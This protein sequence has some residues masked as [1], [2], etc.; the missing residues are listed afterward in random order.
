MRVGIV[1]WNTA[2]LLDACLASLATE[3]ARPQIEVVVVD[4]ASSDGSADV[5]ERHPGVRVIRNDS[6]VGYARAMNQALA[7]GDADVLVALNPDT[8]VPVGVLR[9][10]VDR[11]WIDPLVG[12]VAPRLVDPDGSMQ[13]SGY[14]FPSAATALAEHFL[15]AEP[16]T[17]RWRRRA[18]FRGPVDARGCGDIDWA[19]GAVH[20]IRRSALGDRL[21]YDER[22][23]MYTED[24]ELCWSLGRR[25]WRRRLEADLEVIHV[26]NASGRKQWGTTPTLLTVSGTYDWFGRTHG[27]GAARAWALANAVGSIP[28]GLSLAVR[29]CVGDRVGRRTRAM[30]LLRLLPVH[31]RVAVLGPPPPLDA[32]TA[33]RR[34]PPARFSIRRRSPP[35]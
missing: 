1:S 24:M 32:V 6:N 7:G 31:L 5:A 33:T 23:F 8:V 26:G 4:N 2:E 18:W 3:I 34:P 28:H 9:A 35:T 19:I 12:L 22:W 20:V 11:L 25:G 29:S 16:R 27:A 30:V 13:E 14:R 15:W 17:G 10:L 21:P